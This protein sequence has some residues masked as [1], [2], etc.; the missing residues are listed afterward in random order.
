MQP[1]QLHDIYISLVIFVA[2]VVGASLTYAHITGHA[3]TSAIL[4]KHIPLGQEQFLVV[5]ASGCAGS[6]SSKLDSI[7][8][9][10]EYRS[11]G[12]LKMKISGEL[13]DGL[14]TVEA[15]F[16]SLGQLGGSLAKASFPNGEVSLGSTNINP[17]Q[18]KLSVTSG[19][20]VFTRRFTLP[21]PILLKRLAYDQFRIEY[22][23]IKALPSQTNAIVNQPWLKAVLPEIRKVD[24]AQGKCP[25]EGGFIDI[26]SLIQ[27]AQLLVR[28]LEEYLPGWLE[29]Q[30]G[31]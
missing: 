2:S 26:D 16:N 30:E 28:G 11:K 3:G 25:A 4:K 27:S 12:A 22:G 6:F 17:I 7:A 23:G 18:V 21:G 20:A 9:N 10:F 14:F 5:S 19:S 13:I 15:H 31:T 24:D 29:Q 8:S 1:S